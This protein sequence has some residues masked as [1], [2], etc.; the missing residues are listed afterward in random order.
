MPYLPHRSGS[1]IVPR[2]RFLAWHT[3]LRCEAAECQFRKNLRQ[4]TLLRK[5]LLQEFQSARI[6]AL[7]QPEDRLFAHGGI[8]VRLCDVDQHRHPFTV[9]QLLER[10]NGLLLPSSVRI[11]F[12]GVANFPSHLS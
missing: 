3:H 7:S 12:N 4:T 2:R 10:E 6:S 5:E 11:I 9:L 1:Q 8:P